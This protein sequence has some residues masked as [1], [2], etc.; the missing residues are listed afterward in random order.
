ML[1][2]NIGQSFVNKA[3]KKLVKINPFCKQVCLDDS[4]GDMGKESDPELWK[5]LT[6]GKAKSK[7]VEETDSEGD[8][9]STNFIVE[10]QSM[11]VASYHIVLHEI[12]RSSVSQNEL[13]ILPLEK[14]IFRFLSVQKLIGPG[15][16]GSSKT[17][18]MQLVKLI[19]MRLWNIPVI[20]VAYVHA[21]F[22][23]CDDW[24]A[25]NPQYIFHAL[26]RIER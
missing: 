12:D 21:R 9:D 6:D 7:A 3:L 1:F 20:P 14:G 26:V 10:N 15:S 18:Y 13:F 22:K 25:S 8:V 19:L 23:S 2:I 16:F 5:L 11:S 24:F 4:L 17:L